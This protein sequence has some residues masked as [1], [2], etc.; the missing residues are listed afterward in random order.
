M[1]LARRDV[2]CEC[3]FGVGSCDASHAACAVVVAGV[4]VTAGVADV[5]DLA[6]PFSQISTVGVRLSFIA[7]PPSSRMYAPPPC[8]DTSMPAEGA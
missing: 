4:G 6:S 5:P 2:I 7:A 1:Q 3:A 8:F